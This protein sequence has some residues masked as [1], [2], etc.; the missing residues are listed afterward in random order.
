ML[1][2]VMPSVIL[3]SVLMLSVTLFSISILNV[4]ILNVAMLNVVM[5]SVIRHCVA[6]KAESQLKC[7]H[8]KMAK[9]IAKMILTLQKASSLK[10]P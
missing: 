9:N 6:T 10:N 7:I 1:N 4:V 8:S 5:P 3:F 2:V